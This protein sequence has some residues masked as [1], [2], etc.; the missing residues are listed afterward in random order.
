MLTKRF[1]AHSECSTIG[2]I[3]SMQAIFALGAIVGVRLL[4]KHLIGFVTAAR[5]RRSAPVC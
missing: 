5:Y 4:S 3:V 2:T 1:N